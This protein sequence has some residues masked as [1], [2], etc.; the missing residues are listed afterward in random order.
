LK[1]Q[2]NKLQSRASEKSESIENK[3][4]KSLQGIKTV[5][6]EIPTFRIQQVDSGLEYNYQRKEQHHLKA[7]RITFNLNTL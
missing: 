6:M 1:Q 7:S 4:S 5:H 3:Q 2:E